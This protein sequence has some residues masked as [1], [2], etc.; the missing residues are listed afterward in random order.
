MFDFFINIKKKYDQIWKNII[1]PS[2]QQYSL[3]DL[4]PNTQ[5][6]NGHIIQRKD[7]IIKNQKNQNL[8]CT[9]YQSLQNTLIKFQPCIIYL[10]GNQGSRVESTA[11]INHVMPQFTLVSFDFSGSGKSEGQYV[12]MGFNESKDLEC[13]ISQIKL[14]IKNIGQIIIWG[15]SMGAVTAILCETQVDCLILDS[16]FSDLKQLIQEIALRK[17]KINKIIFDGIFMLIQNKIKEVLN[18]VD[19]FDIKICLKVEKIKCP[20]LFAYSKNDEFILNYHTKNMFNFC[21]SLNKKCIE[22][23]GGHNSFRPFQFY[24][25]VIS[26]LNRFIQNKQIFLL[27]NNQFLLFGYFSS[28]N[29]V[30]NKNLENQNFCF[31]RQKIFSQTTLQDYSDNKKLNSQIS[32]DQKSSYLNQNKIYLSNNLKDNQ[33]TLNKKSYFQKRINL[34]IQL[35]YNFKRN[36]NLFVK[37]LKFQLKFF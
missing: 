3:Q 17:M 33:N 31:K 7:L 11:I 25:Q 20:V 6:I 23:E 30:S 29:N 15:R 22:F 10:H 19:I 36:K 28:K 2:R 18:G 16:G 14:L 9:I 13:V 37:K 27:K 5:I 4:G 8:Q 24:Q 34:Y 1:Q 32:T 26:F 12:T 35:Q 21:K